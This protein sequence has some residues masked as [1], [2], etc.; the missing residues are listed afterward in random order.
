[1]AFAP[2]SACWAAALYEDVDSRPSGTNSPTSLPQRMRPLAIVHSKAARF[3]LAQ[4]ARTRR[5]A[6]TSSTVSITTIGVEESSRTFRRAS[7]SGMRGH[8]MCLTGRDLL[9]YNKQFGTHRNI[10]LDTQR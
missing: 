6:R 10:S 3:K 9:A 8:A 5:T 2:A 4:A 1:M 7:G